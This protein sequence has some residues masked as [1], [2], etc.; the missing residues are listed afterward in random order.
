M[1]VPFKDRRQAGQL[2]AARLEAY[3]NH[4]D[5]VVFGL[6]RGGIPVAYEVARALDAPLDVFLVRKLGMPGHEELAIGAIASGGVRLLNQGLVDAARLSPQ[7]IEAVTAAELHELLRRE[8]VYRGARPVL[9]VKDRTVILVDDGLA[10]GSTMLAAAEAVRRQQ[11][12]RI[13]SAVP[14]VSSVAGD[15]LGDA[16]DEVVFILAPEPFYAVG[17]WYDDFSPTGDREVQDLLAQAEAE[18]QFSA[19]AT[20]A[21]DR[22]GTGSSEGT[23]RNRPGVRVL[24]ASV[25]SDDGV[26]NMLGSARFALLG[27]ATHGTEEFYRQRA[28]LTRRLIEEKRFTAVAVEADWP[29][30]YR[31]NCYVRGESDDASA[32]EALNDFKRFPQWMWRNTVVREFVEWLRAYND[33]Q[34][35][36]EQKVGFYGLDLYSL[37]ASIEAVIRYLDQADPDA[38][39][40]ARAR[41]A[42]L[43]HF[44]DDAQMYGYA[45]SFAAAET[46]E[47]EVV[48]QLVDLRR[49]A[50]ELASRDGR[51]AEDQY[52]SAEQNAR[53]ARNAEAYYRSMFRGRVSSW[54]LRDRHMAESL[55]ALAAHLSR[56]GQM[57]R[58]AVWAHNSHLGDALATQMGAAGELNLGQLVRERY[59]GEACLAG[60]STYQGS[61][62]AASDWGAPAERKRV[63][64]GLSNSYEA[65]FHDIGAQQLVID[66]RN[67]AESLARWLQEPRLQRAIGVIYRP[68]TER[69]SHYFEARLSR[70]FD[71]MM[72]ID[73]THAL[74]PLEWTAEWERG[75]LPETFPFAGEPIPGRRTA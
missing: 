71:V 62:T 58:V 2:L 26:V 40:R 41:Y 52:F 38:A 39:A 42:C 59:A 74:E 56:G 21:D 48:A 25:A 33:D 49:H 37:N 53:L 10:T 29:D 47:D 27:E 17:L 31:V 7:D 46:C 4:D 3:A 18:R 54:N 12:A 51:I 66:L 45:T 73:E 70:Q 65:L 64:P 24:E 5:V 16:V 23:W 34:R 61:V 75:E 32:D 35:S 55:D 72:H 11:P 6:P 1:D 68:E 69:A 57:A 8:R 44:R 50:G 30:A 28:D 19:S 9:P 63:R 20:P 22:R 13:V 36:P 15:Q 60:F 67:H 14:V 43:D